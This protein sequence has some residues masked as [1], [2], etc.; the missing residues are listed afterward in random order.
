M[1]VNAIELVEYIFEG[2]AHL[3]RAFSRDLKSSSRFR[4]FVEV[5][6]DKIRKK[7]RE[8]S[9]D[10]DAIKDVLA[11]IKLAYHLLQIDRFWIIEYERYGTEEHNPDLTV[12]DSELGIVFNLEVKRIR[13]TDVE[14][15]FGEWKQQVTQRIIKVPSKLAFWMDIGDFNTPI[16]LVDRLEA[17]MEYVI[18]YII[19]TIV[20]SQEE[21]PLGGEKRYSVPGFKGVFEFKLRKPPRKPSSETTSYYGGS[22]PDF[23][24]HEEYKKFGDLIC[25]PTHLGQMRPD[26]INILAITT[27][28]STHEDFDL[29]ESLIS[30]EKKAAQ[31]N[32]EF[33]IRKG[34]EGSADFATQLERLSGILFASVFVPVRSAP[35]VLWCNHRAKHPISEDIGKILASDV[36]PEAKGIH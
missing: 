27:D 7:I 23:A 13:C 30:L 15:R 20:K 14:R 2:K 1:L 9:Y 19:E 29:N 31:G 18:S 26:M 8:S 22:F 24:T 11:E 3:F 16:D 4:K 17:N 33:F 28:S 5:Y 21:I 32:D 34:F 35:D 6:R 25:D 12:T 36:L 10:N